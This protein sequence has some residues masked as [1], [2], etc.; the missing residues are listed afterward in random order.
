MFRRN[1]RYVVQVFSLVLAA[2]VVSCGGQDHSAPANAAPRSRVSIGIQVSPAMALVMVAKD[3][4]FFA[5]ESV[6]VEFKE[7]T[8]GKFALQAFLGGGVDYCVSGEV[9]ACLAALQGN[10]VHVVS[11]VVERTVNEVR[12]VVR[13]DASAV[14]PRQFF[15]HKRRKIATSIGGGPEFF[16]YNFLKRHGL[17]STQVQII[18]QDPKEMPAALETG[19]VD[20]IAVFDPFA[21]IAE[22]RLGEKA[23]T[24]SDSTLYSELYVLSA[25]QQQVATDGRT[26]ERMLRALD[27]A[28][29]Y[30][31][32]QPD[33]AKLVV[34]R[35]TKL[36]PSIVDG[37]WSSFV[38]KPALTPLLLQTWRQETL[39]AKERGKIPPGTP[40]RDLRQNIEP[41][42]LRAVTPSAVA[43]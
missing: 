9:P 3:R 36:D 12:V 1:S 19:S 7:F 25:R 15:T 35:Y 10:D 17:D 32:E 41:K 27:R 40:E 8:A 11:Q 42:F 38:F 14:S 30:M 18:S 31:A 39:W 20:A 37:I 16:T 22:K 43:P 23:T 33:S 2:M 6:D 24:F 28:A 21:F 34:Q 26:I 29:T 4:H 5:A 13:R